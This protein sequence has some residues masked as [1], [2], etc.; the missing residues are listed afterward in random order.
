MKLVKS[1]FTVCALL[2]AGAATAQL[3]IHPNQPGNMG[4][5][6]T[7]AGSGTKVITSTCYGALNGSGTG[8]IFAYDKATAQTFT[9]HSFVG[10]A[11]DVSYP[12][13]TSPFTASDGHLYGQGTYGGAANR[14]GVYKQESGCN[15]GLIYSYGV[16][17]DTTGSSLYYSYSNLNEL[18]DGKLYIIFT[19]GGAAYGGQLLRMNKDGSGIQVL[20][21]FSS[22]ALVP[23]SAASIAN[24]TAEYGTY[25]A[26]WAYDGYYPCGFAVEG[27]DGKVYGTTQDGGYYGSGTGTIWRVNKDGTG[28]EIIRDFNNAAKLNFWKDAAGVP[29]A[30]AYG[31]STTYGNVSFGSDSRIYYTAGSG[32]VGNLGIIGRVDT[33]GANRATVYSFT[34]A[35]GYA[36]YRGPLVIEKDGISKKIYG[37]AVSGGSG[38]AGTI[39]SI[40]QDGT[41]FTYMHKFVYS[42]TDGYSPYAGLAYDGTKLWGTT[43]YGGAYNTGALYSID[44]SGANFTV[45]ASFT[46]TTGIESDSC[47]SGGNASVYAY[48]PSWERVTFSNMGI[49][50][51]PACN[52]P[53]GVSFEY[54]NANKLN[55]TAALLEWKTGNES[56]VAGFEIER[57]ADGKKFSKIG[58][59]DYSG[60]S[61]YEYSFADNAPYGSLNFYRIK[62]MDKDGKFTYSAIKSVNFA[63][64]SSVNIY[65]NPVRDG[66]LNIAGLDG[67]ETINIYTVTGQH[68]K[69]AKADNT[70]LQLNINDLAE[71]IYELKIIKKGGYTSSYKIVKSR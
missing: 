48:Y 43:A 67:T 59:K 11:S 49:D 4:G 70:L 27:P 61:G 3:Y 6:T 55:A 57:S 10:G 28:Y 18:S 42:A 34:A 16:G 54:F 40:N 38:N 53:L 31:E 5:N 7:S 19:Y 26:T 37:T 36:P 63:S 17:S 64:H 20:H 60:Q 33:N 14:G 24:T 62:E 41:G 35:G 68:I 65:P 15:Y 25:D 23:R 30:S 50:C 51:A 29:I 56:N 22:T 46:S 2:G 12:F 8:T 1:L 69:T 71:G 13:Y 21:T 47:V 66:N 44:P 32:G 52:K 45:A 58:Y 9:T 39:W